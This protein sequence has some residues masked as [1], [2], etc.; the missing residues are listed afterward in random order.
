MEETEA[1]AA[2]EKKGL[3]IVAVIIVLIVI[4]FVFRLQTA[5]LSTIQQSEI[6]H[7]K[8]KRFMRIIFYIALSLMIAPWVMQ[9]FS[10]LTSGLVSFKK[11]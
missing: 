3:I 7:N 6:L 10:M 5:H 11:T 8:R 1:F 2:F 9:W 4:D